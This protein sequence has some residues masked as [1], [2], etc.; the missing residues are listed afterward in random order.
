MI[1]L[2]ATQNSIWNDDWPEKIAENTVNHKA[3]TAHQVYDSDLSDV[4]QHKT[5]DDKER[6]GVTDN[7]GNLWIHVHF[8][9]ET[10]LNIFSELRKY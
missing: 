9:G 10:N 4:F 1:K 3:D 7:I 6:C 5:Q 2:H 8:F